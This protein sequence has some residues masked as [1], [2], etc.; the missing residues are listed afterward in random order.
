[1]PNAHTGVSRSNSKMCECMQGQCILSYPAR[2]LLGAL[3]V[4]GP[5]SIETPN[6]PHHTRAQHKRDSGRQGLDRCGCTPR[7]KIARVC[8]TRAKSPLVCAFHVRLG[9]GAAHR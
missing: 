7:H 6:T 1:M 8:S 9:P 3:A 4:P 5:L 2:A